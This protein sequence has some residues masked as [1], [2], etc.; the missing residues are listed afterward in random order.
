MVALFLAALAAVNFALSSRSR[1][2]AI[3]TAL[4][5]IELVASLLASELDRRPW[6]GDFASLA[7]H[8]PSG[9]LGNG[10]QILISDAAGRIVASNLPPGSAMTLSDHIGSTSLDAS[11]NDR[12]KGRR[13]VLRDGAEAVATMRALA[14]PR[15]ILAIVHPLDE[16]LAEWRAAAWRSALLVISTSLV[17]VAIAAA[18]LAQTGRAHQAEKICDRIRGRM[19]TALS[20]GRCG[21]WD[22]DL[23]RGQIF[24]SQ[25]MFEMLGMAGQTRPLS[26]GELRALVHPDDESL[27]ELAATLATPGTK[28]I[29]HNFRMRN[30]A[31]DWIWLRARAEIVHDEGAGT[32]RLVGIAVDVTEQQLMAQ[33]SAAADLRL[34]DAI[35]A[36]SEAFVLWD[37]DNRLVTCNSK[38]RKLHGLPAE[39]LQAGIPYSEL[40]RAGSLP[41]VQAQSRPDERATSDARTYEAQLVDGRWLQINERRTKDGGY[42]SVGTDITALKRHE[43]QLMDSERRLMATVADLRSSRHTL[44]YQAQQL[45]DLAERYLEQKAE[46]ELASHAKSEFLANMS[47]ELRTPLNAIIGFS[48]TMQRQIFGSLGC[49]RYVDYCRGINQSGEYLLGVISDILDMSELEAGHTRLAKTRFE[50]DD[51]ID[52]ALEPIEG[53]ARQK[54]IEI[55]RE[56]LPSPLMFGDRAAVAKILKIVLIN[57]VKFTPDGG[58]VTVR[59]RRAGPVMNIYVEDTGIGIPSEALRRIARPFE[60]PEAAMRN[61]MR[62]SGLG[63]AIARSLIELHGGSMRIRSTVGSGTIV[64]IRLP[65]P[66]DVEKCASIGAAA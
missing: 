6:G 48:D 5:E 4:T 61:G 22:W 26:F 7:K 40:M 50:I 33:R 41:A 63:L 59:A 3:G 52:R 60:Q 58:R 66:V 1:D 47:H 2:V 29:D 24:W 21:L 35:E 62:G 34:S 25:S 64:L 31:G 46:A 39:A 42:V 38:F 43:E 44:E 27:T 56:P 18:Y 53:V 55:R 32:P 14:E 54:R 57:A 65:M 13:L 30:A 15:G 45:A 10:R 12:I 17:L 11:T 51:V 8:L 9:A 19:D 36:I 20:R 23:G 37:A 16:I 49:E 28:A